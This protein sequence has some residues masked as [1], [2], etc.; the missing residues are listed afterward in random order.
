MLIRSF[1]GEEEAKQWEKKLAKRQ[2]EI[3]KKR[4]FRLVRPFACVPELFRQLR[5]KRWALVLGTSGKKDAV[6][7]Y[8]KLLQIEGLTDLEISADDV[9]RSKPHPDIFEFALK[10]LDGIGT[11]RILAV[12]AE[13]YQ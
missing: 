6:V 1:L 7:R 12:G 9:Q 5:K 2:E 13:L 8:K 4:H 3:F 11:D 10:K